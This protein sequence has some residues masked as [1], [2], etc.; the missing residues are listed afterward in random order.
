MLNN[1]A[2][3]STNYNPII[4]YIRGNKEEIMSNINNDTS[5]DKLLE[6]FQKLIVTMERLNELNE[7]IRNH[8]V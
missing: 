1:Y 8:I 6:S 2:N 5:N 4:N 3:T 7:S